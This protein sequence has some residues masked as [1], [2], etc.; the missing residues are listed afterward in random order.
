LSSTSQLNP[1]LVSKAQLLRA[2]SLFSPR[3]DHESLIEK[4]TLFLC[5]AGLKPVSAAGS[6]HWLTTSLGGKRE[7]D[8]PDAVRDLLGQLGF[9]FELE[10]RSDVVLA[11]VS[12]SRRTLAEYWAMRHDSREEGRLFGYPMTA[13]DAYVVGESMLADQQSA[14]QQA[15]GAPVFSTFRL[16]R[17]HA[18]AELEVMHQWWAML[19]LYGWN[20]NIFDD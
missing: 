11:Y 9:V 12:L 1:T 15:F 8:D 16:S 14:A 3:G 18:A 2:S 5:L 20:E 10:V 6:G 4:K 19:E 17:E 13:V 7:V